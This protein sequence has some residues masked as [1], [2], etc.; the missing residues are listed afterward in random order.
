ML[1]RH[2]EG[3]VVPVLR[4]R[5]PSLL[6]HGLDA[7]ERLL[8]RRAVRPSH[9]A[10]RP[11]EDGPGGVGRRRARAAAESA[12]GEEAG[13]ALPAGACVTAVCATALVL[14]SSDPL[15]LSLSLRDREPCEGTR[16]SH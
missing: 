14:R 15:S 4:P 13:R 9:G 10:A 3:R 2:P 5:W 8:Q 6:R 11:F 1:L 16:R 7:A 12:G